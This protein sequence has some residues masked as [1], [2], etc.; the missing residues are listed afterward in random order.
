MQNTLDSPR[1]GIKTHRSSLGNLGNGSATH[2]PQER[3]AK[4]DRN[5][6]TAQLKTD[7]ALL[8][9]PKP[10]LISNRVHTESGPIIIRKR[11]YTE[12]IMETDEEECF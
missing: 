4:R 6:L 7:Q 1:I 8:E 10:I 3:S 11:L 12:F 9:R 2:R 5:S